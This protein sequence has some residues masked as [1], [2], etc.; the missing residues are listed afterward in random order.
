MWLYGRIYKKGDILRG[1]KIE[2]NAR[3]ISR[4]KKINKSGRHKTQSIVLVDNVECEI[5]R[6][7]DHYGENR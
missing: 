5:I 2:C 4:P 6:E 7:L 3:K 1:K